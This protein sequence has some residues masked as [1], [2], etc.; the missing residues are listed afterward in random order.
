MKNDWI[1]QKLIKAHEAEDELNK[2]I[3]SID[4]EI[5]LLKKK[6]RKLA[7]KVSKNMKNRNHLINMIK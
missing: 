2:E 3:C 7:S 5:D 6:K 4:K 1:K